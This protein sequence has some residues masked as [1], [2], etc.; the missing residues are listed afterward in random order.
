MLPQ[1]SIDQL[2]KLRTD[3]QG[4][5]INDKVNKEETK[6]PNLYWMDNPVDGGRIQS[7][8]DFTN[9]DNKLQ[10]TAFKSKLVNK[11]IS[12]KI[13]TENMKLHNLITLKEFELLNKMKLKNKYGKEVLNESWDIWW[14]NNKNS[15]LLMDEYQEYLSDYK[16]N[17]S[18]EDPYAPSFEQWAKEKYYKIKSDVD[19]ISYKLGDDEDGRSHM[20]TYEKKDETQEIEYKG[21]TITR[22]FP[23]G[24]YEVRIK[25]KFLKFDRLGDAKKAIDAEKRT[26]TKAK[27]NEGNDIQS[28]TFLADQLANSMEFYESPE[29]FAEHIG[30]ECG[31]DKEVLKQIYTDYWNL[32]V[33]QRS[34]GFDESIEDWSEW[35]LD[36]YDVFKNESVKESKET[37]GKEEKYNLFGV[38]QEIDAKIKKIGAFSSFTKMKDPKTPRERPVL[39]AGQF[40]DNNVVSGYINRIEGNKVFVESLDKPGEIIE[41]SI[42]DAVKIKKENK[43][44][45]KVKEFA[46]LKEN[47]KD[48]GW[49]EKR[50]N[51][52]SDAKSFQS[53]KRREG[54]KTKLE[55]HAGIANPYSIVKWKK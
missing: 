4:E 30:N 42:K 22:L 23:S 52:L 46:P 31:M 8:E 26:K 47:K 49:E 29:E 17:T 3:V 16:I 41:V 7:Y 11:S 34:F 35:V 20:H 24:Y 6:L 12:E 40:I 10:T 39:N 37:K 15:E 38:A 44:D 9:K 53:K 54:Y 18:E 28:L 33:K 1:K 27:V 51:F 43:E 5:D 2:R 25:G 14:E 45:K 48:D 21:V 55:K 13:I 32:P 19:D 50:F 36:N